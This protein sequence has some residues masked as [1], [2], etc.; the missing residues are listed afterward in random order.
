MSELEDYLDEVR[1]DTFIDPSNV[2]D[3][4]MKLP[5]IKH[6]WSSRLIRCKINGV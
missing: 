5:G 6:K 4:Q 3:V 1:G 2:K